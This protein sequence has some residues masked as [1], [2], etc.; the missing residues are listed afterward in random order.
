LIL[1]QVFRGPEGLGVRTVGFEEARVWGSQVLLLS[2][3]PSVHDGE[4]TY[5]NRGGSLQL[6]LREREHWARPGA[7]EAAAGEMGTER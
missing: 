6:F 5:K 4:R 3:C 2:A 1:D 7:S